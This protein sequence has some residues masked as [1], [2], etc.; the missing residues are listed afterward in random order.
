M[1]VRGVKCGV[2]GPVKGQSHIPLLGRL[3]KVYLKVEGEANRIGW[4]G[5]ESAIGRLKAGDASAA[6]IGSG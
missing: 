5:S 1:H 6:S 3:P 2:R 4:P